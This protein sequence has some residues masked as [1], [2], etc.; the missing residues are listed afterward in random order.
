MTEVAP[1][2]ARDMLFAF[3]DDLSTKRPRALREPLNALVDYLSNSTD[4][5]VINLLNNYPFEPRR[6]DIPDMTA[7]TE[8]LLKRFEN[9]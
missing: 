3:R 1:E 6:R 7:N 4:K 2:R 8:A 5:M 9:D